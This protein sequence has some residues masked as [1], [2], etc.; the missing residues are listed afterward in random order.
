MFTNRV[1][2]SKGSIQ[3]LCNAWN[4]VARGVMLLLNVFLYTVY[5]CVLTV[6]MSVMIWMYICIRYCPL[7][8]TSS[9]ALSVVLPPAGMM[10]TTVWPP[11]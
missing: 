10:W 8:G 7:S 1:T 9:P 11:L 4:L 2:T 5:L 6:P 3:A